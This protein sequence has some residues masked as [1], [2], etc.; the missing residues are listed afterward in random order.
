M[1]DKDGY[2][3]LNYS[4]MTVVLLQAVKEQQEIITAK[5]EQLGE[6]EERVEYLEDRLN[7]IEAIL[8]TNTANRD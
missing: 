3:A 4:K 8:S 1:I 2:K 6:L 5:D 7:R